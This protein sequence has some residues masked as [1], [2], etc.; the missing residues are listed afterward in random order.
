MKTTIVPGTCCAGE[1]CLARDRSDRERKSSSPSGATGRRPARCMV[2]TI[3]KQARPTDHCG[4]TPAQQVCITK[5]VRQ[6]GRQGGREADKTNK[7]INKQI[8]WSTDKRVCAYVCAYVSIKG[9][10][11][12]GVSQIHCHLSY[13]R[14]Q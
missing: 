3:V 2:E 9:F 14:R 5:L 12:G 13:E 7:Q 1:G 10:Y 8:T 6:A 4:V 11:G